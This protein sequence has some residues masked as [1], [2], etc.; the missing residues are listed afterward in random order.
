[1]TDTDFWREIYAAKMKQARDLQEQRAAVLQE[2]AAI[3][4]RFGFKAKA[5]LQEPRAGDSYA[6]IVENPHA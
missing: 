4:K 3:E 6:F 1:M 5:S 2:A